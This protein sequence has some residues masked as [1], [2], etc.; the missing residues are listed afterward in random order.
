MIIG[1]FEPITTIDYPDQ[2]AAVVFTQGCIWRCKYCHNTHLHD[3]KPDVVY[4]WDEYI[5]PFMKSR[6]GLLDGFVFSG[7]EAI[8]HI[9]LLDK[10]LEIKE[11]GF[12]VGL[13]TAGTAPSRLA[14]VLPACDWVGLDIKAPIDKYDSITCRKDTGKKAYDSLDILY[15]H[16]N[17]LEYEVRTTVDPTLLTVG[18]VYT[19]VD[20]IEEKTDTYVLQQY[21]GPGEVPL[22]NTIDMEDR[23][24][25]GSRFKRFYTRGEQ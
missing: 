12:L 25:I 3:F 6:V 21:R 9:D 22:I 8:L 1:G 17:E 4:D 11:L 24:K 7:G 13:H 20:S 10:M 16:R 19:I 15:D 5:I 2:L 14:H 18:D 23:A